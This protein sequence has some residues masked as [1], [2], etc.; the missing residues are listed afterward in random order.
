MELVAGLPALLRHGRLSLLAGLGL[1]ILAATAGAAAIV[2]GTAAHA[3]SSHVATCGT[4]A[5]SIPATSGHDELLTVIAPSARSQT[6]IFQMYR[7]TG[8]CFQSVAGPYAAYVGIN[9]VSARH[10]E[11]DLTTPIG[12]FGIETTMYGV[13]PN[14]GVTYRYHQ[15][16]CGDWWDEDPR[17]ALYNHFVHVRCDTT[18]N[19]AGNS[20]SLWTKVPAYDY[21]AVVNYNT[22][23][24]V[25]ARGSAIFLHV[26]KNSPTTG[27][28]SIAKV[29]LLKV[30]RLLRTSEHPVIYINTR[31]SLQG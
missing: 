7:R 12:L 6:A 20:E 1:A 10:H 26:S 5:D 19:I 18:P 22:S 3:T 27:C 16:T 4:L 8:A 23:P 9:G 2:P 28:V 15:F 25:P 21:F 31:A 17:S 14:P 24:V 29:H 13:D 30:L 11:G